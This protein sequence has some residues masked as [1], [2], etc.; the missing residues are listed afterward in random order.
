MFG[1]HQAFA[2]Q[3]CVVSGGAQLRDVGTGMDPAF[4]DT[5]TCRGDLFP[6]T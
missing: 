1:T 5:D 2:D 4:G 3:K 6:Q